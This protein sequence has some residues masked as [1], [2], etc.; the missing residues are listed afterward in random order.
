[1]SPTI[2]VLFIGGA[3]SIGGAPALFWP[4]AAGTEPPPRQPPVADRAALGEY[5]LAAYGPIKT[6]AEAQVALDKAVVDIVRKGGGVL[7]VPPGAPA[8]W[9]FENQAPSST[10]AD[11]PSVTIVDRRF[12]YERTLVPSNGKLSGL[13]W[14]SRHLE[15]DVRQNVDTLFGVHSTQAIGTNI[16][17]GT[18]SYI[19]PSLFAATAGSDRR[20]YLPTVRGLFAG[21]YVNFH[22]APRE[23]TG[24]AESGQI[25]SLGWDRAKRL[26]YVTLDLKLDH[27]AES[28][29][30]SKHVVN[31]LSL[32]EN[33]NSDNQSMA[34]QVTRNL[35]GQG[36]AFGISST[37]RNQGNVMSAAGDEGALT[38][39]AD[40]FNDLSPFHSTVES[41][42]WPKQELVYAPGSVRN[43]TLGTSRPLLN[44]NRKKWVTAGTVHIVAPGYEDPWGPSLAGKR[45]VFGGGA[46]IGSTDCGWR[47]DV[48]GRFFAVDEPSEYLD[49]AGDGA[50]GYTG[51]PERRAYRWY[52][53]QKLEDRPDGTMR[54]FVERTFWWSGNEAAPK[55]YDFQNYTRADH[56]RPLKYVI[57]PGAYVTD[58]SRAWTN[59]EVRGGTVDA[60]SPRTLKLAP[61]GDVGTPF[62]FEPGD[63][64]TQAIGQDP[65]N[66]TGLRVRHHN[67]LPTTI[68]D[69]SFQAVN[70][71]RVTVGAAIAVSG[72]S[73]G[74]LEADVK[75]SKDKQPSFLHGINLDASTDVGL[76]F[77]ADVRSAAIQFEQPHG[78]AQP[79]AW[80][81]QDP[82]LP[83]HTLTVDPQKGGFELRGNG[84]TLPQG[85]ISAGEKPANNL[86]GISVPVPA[87]SRELKVRFDRREPDGNYAIAVQPDWITQDAVT[88]KTAEGFTVV[89]GTAPQKEGKIDW[90]LMR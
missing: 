15:R 48:V 84:I 32:L 88:E 73:G 72:G 19:Q 9:K 24:P 49:P 17:G 2:R 33:S 46:I 39:A 80:R 59:A 86:R 58:I 64:V 52:L 8:D 63:E 12:G 5:D 29:V 38:F 62:D 83:A 21:M 1:M 35:Y 42:D 65:W 34:L 31:S 71:G 44:L 26:P 66:P 25:K 70:F 14:A 54:L 55:L 23:F 36:D 79:I 60:S 16:A 67:Y 3:I 81:L 27:P 57:A 43:H 69:C 50:A 78:R 28:L 56:K 45:P 7:V 89:F 82:S 51:A 4:A 40:I 30:S 6:A 87:N 11:G 75:A 18:A 76:R 20:V 13:Y 41:V 68:P 61:G 22:A 77:G 74:G 47:Q 37:I 85:G 10:R 90:I 53:V